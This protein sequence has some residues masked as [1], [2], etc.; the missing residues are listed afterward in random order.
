MQIS[1]KLLLLHQDMKFII[2]V[3]ITGIFLFNYY[4]LSAQLSDNFN[5]N[6]FFTNPYWQGDSVKFIVNASGELQLNAPP[7]TGQAYLSTSSSLITNTEWQLYVKLDFSPSTSNLLK[8]YLVSN[9]KDLTDTLNGYFLKIGESGNTDGIDLYKQTGLTETL[10]IDGLTGT[11]AKSTNELSIK[12]LTDDTGNWSIYADTLGGTEFSLQGNGWDTSFTNSNYFGVYCKYT[13]TRSDKFYFDNFYIGP[14]LIDTSPPA[15]DSI[16]VISEKELEIYFNKGVNKT[17]AENII[18]YLVSP[19]IGIP[20]FAARDNDST[21]KVYLLFNSS[22]ADEQMY[23]LKTQ[24]IFDFNQNVLVQDSIPFKYFATSKY[25]LLINEIFADPD[26]IVAL[27]PYEF[28]ELYNNSYHDI[29]IKNWKISDLTGTYTLPE[30]SIEPDSYL[31]ICPQTANSFYSA[32]GKTYS[33]PSW[34]SLNNDVDRLTLKD[35]NGQLIHTVFYNENWHSNELKKLGG[36]TLEMIDVHN[37]CSGQSN[38]S[39]SIDLSGGTPGRKNSIASINPDIISPQI[40]KSYLQD[41]LTIVIELDE[42][43]DSLSLMKRSNYFID[44][45]IGNPENITINNMNYILLHLAQPLLPKILYTLTVSNISDCV[46]NIIEPQS[47]PLGIPEPIDSFDIVINEILFNP[48]PFG[49]DFVEIYNRSNKILDLADLR[50]ANAINGN[51]DQISLLF[52]EPIL[53]FPNQYAI[54]SEDITIVKQ[55]YFSGDIGQA[56]QISSIP[57]YAD[58]QGEVLLI[59]KT[60]NTIDYFSYNEDMHFDLLNNTEGVSLE[61]I[62]YHVLQNENNWHSAASTV[63][64]ATPG[65]ANSQLHIETTDNNQFSIEPEVFSPDLDGYNDFLMIHYYLEEPGYIAHINIFDEQGR[66]LRQLANNELLSSSGTFIWD[67]STTEESIATFGIYIVAIE[68]FNLEGYRKRFK[69][70]VVLGGM[71]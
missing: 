59:N 6:D 13:S 4:S 24:N 49:K 27:P 57:T 28:I 21:N 61:R 62:S 34:P 71:R 16:A 17:S 10:I 65:Y 38:W 12:V 44:N 37:P 36:W 25:E 51:P 48:Y 68:L 11:V 54:I 20:Q 64:Y 19:D 69:L 15:I 39:S 56:I 52:Q 35:H 55:Q 2:I 3:Y 67:G 60:G 14:I 53:F 33:M 66:V 70:P 1:K 43:S 58:D 29:H 30:A 9:Q 45:A 22:F 18:N 31:I 26:P 23:Y 63:G 46:G 47:I 32:Y 8:I 50:L 5:D 40:I 41:S 7:V 42:V